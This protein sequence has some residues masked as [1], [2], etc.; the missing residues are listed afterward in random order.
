MHMKEQ[1]AKFTYIIKWIFLLFLWEG[2]AQIL[3]TGTA[4]TTPIV[5]HTPCFY[6]PF[7]TNYYYY[8]TKMRKQQRKE[9]CVYRRT[10]VSL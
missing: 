6:K 4:L 9:Q 1:V 3:N 10:I 2:G 8:F 7:N 5:I